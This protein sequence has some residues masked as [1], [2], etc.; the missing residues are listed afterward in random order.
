MALCIVLDEHGKVL[1]PEGKTREYKLNL[2]NSDRVLQSVVA[3]ANSAGGELVV[4]VRDD[5]IVVGV[6]DPLVEEQRLAHLVAD[7]VRPQLAPVIDLVTVQDKTVLVAAVQ[8]GS[9]RPYYVKSMG[10]YQGTYY[11]TGAGNRQAGVAMVDELERSS[12]GRSFDQLPCVGATMDD[13]DVPMLSKILGREMTQGVLRTLQLTCL[14]QGKTVPTNGGVLVGSHHP[15]TFM[16]FAWVQCARFR[17]PGKRD[18]TDQKDIYG[19]LPLA[20]DEVMK[21]LR[22][23]AFLSAD[24]VSGP[25]RREDVWS[26]PMESLQELVVNAL[27]HSSYANHGT[28]IKVAFLD[29][30]IW[31]ESPG[32]LVPG[33]TV[34]LMR[35]GVSQVRNP[36]IA[37][38]FKEMSLIERWGTGIPD[39]LRELSESGLPEPDIEESVERLRITVHIQSH[40]PLKYRVD[41]SREQTSPVGIANSAHVPMSGAY[42]P[43]SASAILRVAEAGPVH[44]VDLL[45]AAGLSQSSN[46]YRRHVLPLLSAGLLELSIPETPRSPRQRYLITQA[47][48]QFLARQDNE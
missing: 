48:R 12:R 15:E 20:V 44:R 39:V 14:E 3:F 35:Q 40:D 5:G 9:Q 2:T 11:R 41:E 19:P 28:A 36:V 4:G 26:I 34:E 33:M 23:N 7:S 8:L 24:F 43:K 37:R 18:I 30:Q 31:I 10:K 21:F 32:G 29:E 46:N 25:R 27:V 17:G 16:P 45:A 47:G 22:A 1:E 38:V 42:V 13:L 6:D